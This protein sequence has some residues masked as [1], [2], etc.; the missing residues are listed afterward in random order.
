M[1]LPPPS[2]ILQLGNCFK[3]VHEK[4]NKKA[5]VALKIF[6]TWLE[7]YNMEEIL[8]A[9]NGF[10]RPFPF[11]FITT[12]AFLLIDIIGVFFPSKVCRQ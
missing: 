9:Y 3:R 4:R 1:S 7:Q 2:Y 11:F 12:S 6:N 10:L 8:N 5:G